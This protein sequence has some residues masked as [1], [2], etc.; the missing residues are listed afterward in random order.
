MNEIVI[1]GPILKNLL[2]QVILRFRE[3]EVSW[4]T[5]IKVMFSR[6]RLRH[7]YHRFLWPEEDGTIGT[8][9]MTRVTFRVT[10]SPYVAIRTK[11]K[12]AEDAGMPDAL[13]ANIYVDDYPRIG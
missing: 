11:W 4:A 8:F 9:E 7:D 13:A 1:G 5:D 10:R 6:I 12:A 3:G 2:P